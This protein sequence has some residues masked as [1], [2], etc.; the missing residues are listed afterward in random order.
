MLTVSHTTVTGDDVWRA[1]RRMHDVRLR[2]REHCLLRLRD[3]KSCPEI[4]P[5]LSREED[6]MRSWGHAFNQGGLQGRERDAIPGRP[7]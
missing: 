2:E 5:W 3:G 4:A 1:L 7:A 6:T